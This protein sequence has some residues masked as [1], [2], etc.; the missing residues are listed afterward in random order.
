MRKHILA[1]ITFY[2]NID[3]DF[4]KVKRTKKNETQKKKKKTFQYKY[5]FHPL[6]VGCFEII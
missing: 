4:K 1:H 3:V 6:I 5:A 2:Q